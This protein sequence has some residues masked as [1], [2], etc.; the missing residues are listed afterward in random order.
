M[1]S[2]IVMIL[3]LIAA[4]CVTAQSIRL[5]WAYPSNELANADSNGWPYNFLIRATNQVGSNWLSWQVVYDNAASNTPV[6]GFDGTNY[7][8]SITNPV[9]PGPW[10]FVASV[11]NIWGEGGPSNTSSVPP[12]PK[13]LH[14]KIKQN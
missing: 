11:S 3:A 13:V 7:T 8:Y 5:E 6:T 9:L 12:V 14:T 2:W 4:A 10:F 1:K